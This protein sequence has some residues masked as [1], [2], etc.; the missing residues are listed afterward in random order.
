M[1]S[2]DYNQRDWMGQPPYEAPEYKSSLLRTPRKPLL[3]MP[4]TLSEITGPI[5]G[6]D[7]LEKHDNDLTKNA[8]TGVEPQGQRMIV[9]GRVMDENGHP[10]PNT[11]I[12]IWQA[13]AAG[14]YIHVWDTHDAPLDPNFNG[15]G[16][17]M[18]DE[19]GDYK[20]ITIMPGAYPWGNHH[21][22][23]RPSHIHFS[24]FGQSFLTRMVT[25]MYFSGDPLLPFDPLFNSIADEK[26]RN[27]LIANFE[28]DLTTPDW[29]LGYRFDI[30]LRGRKATPM[31]TG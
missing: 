18:T 25:Q 13:N 15:G 8:G 10:V 30:V 23:W 29:A 7:V 31:E 20:L 27:L 24:L 4:Q 5:F 16:R 9:T 21:N 28:L 3:P 12:E 2:N 26:L 1:Q 11:L 19:N 14:R 6:H 22:A 17:V